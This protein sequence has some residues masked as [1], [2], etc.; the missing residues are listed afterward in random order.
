ML[1]L[2]HVNVKL[3]SLTIKEWSLRKNEGPLIKKV[4]KQPIGGVVLHPLSSKGMK[5]R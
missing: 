4:F 5:S 2:L 3:T 1:S